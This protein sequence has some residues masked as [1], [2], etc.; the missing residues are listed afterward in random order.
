MKLKSISVENYPPLENFEIKDLGEIIILAGANGSGKTRL[1]DAIIQSF[2]SPRSPLNGMTIQATR[3]DQEAT[4]WGS[5]E[6]V[7]NPGTRNDQLHKYMAT[8][9]RG[10]TY[11]GSVI[12]ID[13]NRSVQPVTFNSIALE[14]PDPDDEELTPKYFLTPF[15]DRWSDI[16]NKIFQKV[17]SRDN[18]I[19]QYVKQN[20]KKTNSDTLQQFPD[21]FI[22]YQ[23]IF[24]KL[25]PGK[26]LEAINPKN[27][28]DFH[29]IMDGSGSLPFTTL[30][31]G[32]QEVIKI[33]FNLLWKK[34]S[35]CIIFVDEPELH[36]HPTLTFRLIETLK[37]IGKGTNQYFFLTHSAD[38]ISTYYA[39]GDVYFIDS[40]EASGNQAKSLSTIGENHNHTARALGANLGIFAVGKKI[41]FV[42]GEYASIDRLTYHRLAQEAF[43][44]SYII[45]AGSVENILSL[46]R[47]SRE[48]QQSIFGIDFFMIRDRDGLTNEQISTLQENPGFKCL[49]RRH[50]ENYFLD[51]EV[52]SLVAKHFYLDSD[53][54]NIDIVEKKL[55]EIAESLLNHSVL[56]TM[57]QHVTLNGTIDSPRVAN[58]NEKSADDIELEFLSLVDESVSEVNTVCG[59]DNLK[60]KFSRERTR[61]QKSLE[62]NTWKVLFPG[63]L[64]F[65]IYCGILEV[66]PNQVRQA[67]LD[68]AIKKKPNIFNEINNILI[69]FRELN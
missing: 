43:P 49:R 17:A 54:A 36:L 62:K 57:K 5:E 47:V 32:E 58:A 42:E 7:L 50:L 53:W 60:K 31:S 64:I 41:I 13:S 26:T 3:K 40:D 18:K 65:N 69:G 34:I 28:Q 10:G 22:Q 14:T 52:L 12:Q 21:P 9:T 55:K 2:Q 25:L 56:L 16:V 29:Y 11:T 38:L 51:A 33:V 6:L 45:P 39:T 23:Q 19:A 59:S 37:D 46:N 68:I 4:A 27:L 66:S 15:S 44:E 61:L 20:P 1:K 48:L 67:Y 63:K 24:A 30:S 35:H 8:R